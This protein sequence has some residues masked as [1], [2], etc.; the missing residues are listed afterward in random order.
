M[1]DL[2]LYVPRSV[3]DGASDAIRDVFAHFGLAAYRSQVLE[4]ALIGLLIARRLPIRSAIT[5]REI[6]DLDAWARD[7]TL[8]QLVARLRDEVALGEDAAVALAT[9]LRMRNRLTHGYF[10]ERAVMFCTHSGPAEMLSE[11][12]EAQATIERA[13]ELVEA[14]VRGYRDAVGL[15]DSMVQ[16]E[17]Q[18]MVDEFRRDG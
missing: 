10:A 2:F 15:D 11:L 14:A 12:W 17:M 3:A 4:E 5:R 18:R 8:G 13:T 6:D 9:A 1:N 16:A 7:R